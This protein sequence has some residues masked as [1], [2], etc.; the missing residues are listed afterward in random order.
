MI[1]NNRLSSSTPS[2]HGYNGMLHAK[3]L[4]AT[5]ATDLR[6]LMPQACYKCKQSWSYWEEICI[7]TLIHRQRIHKYRDIFWSVARG[8]LSSRRSMA[9]WALPWF[10][11]VM[12]RVITCAAAGQLSPQRWPSCVTACPWPLPLSLPQPTTFPQHFKLVIQY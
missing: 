7:C 9:E 6:I 2:L 10:Y 5:T 11:R 4:S 1:E 12:S 3:P 8:I